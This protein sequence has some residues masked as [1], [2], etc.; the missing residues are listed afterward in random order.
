MCAAAACPALA[1]AGR[2]APP[3]S[4]LQKQAQPSGTARC[5]KP[6]AR[7]PRR[8]PRA[9]VLASGTWDAPA[10]LF[11]TS[12]RAALLPLQ[13][14]GPAAL[15]PGARAEDGGPAARAAHA[16]HV[17]G[18][19]RATGRAA[20]VHSTDDGGALRVPADGRGRSPALPPLCRPLRAA[21]GRHRARERPRCRRCSSTRLASAPRCCCTRTT[22][23]PTPTATRRRPCRSGRGPT[24][25]SRAPSPRCRRCAGC[26]RSR[27]RRRSLTRRPPRR[28]A[29]R[30]GRC[31]ASF[32]RDGR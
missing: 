18:H 14:R 27:R 32:A 24:P 28:S 4:A 13:L 23:T 5:Q 25:R 12:L 8:R 29:C 22:P 3:R 21:G 7:A 2:F 16:A 6:A 9:Q 17:G 31:A 11:P 15:L 1:S 20:D 19:R 30:P 26:S 10:S